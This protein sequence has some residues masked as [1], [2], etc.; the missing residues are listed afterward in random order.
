MNDIKAKFVATGEV[1][2]TLKEPFPM[3]TLIPSAA[4]Y[5]A[6]QVANVV[7]ETDKY[8]NLELDLHKMGMVTDQQNSAMKK[9]NVDFWNQTK[10]GIGAAA[11]L[12]IDENFFSQV[13]TVLTSVDQAFSLRKLADYK[14]EFVQEYLDQM[15][16]KMLAQVIPTFGEEFSE[17]SNIDVVLSLSHN[18]FLKG[19]PDSKRGGFQIDKKGNVKITVNAAMGINFEKDNGEWE[20]ARNIYMTFEYKFRAY[21]GWE[22]YG[23]KFGF[24]PKTL[25]VTKM[26]ILNKEGKEEENE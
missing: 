26:R 8:I 15:N 1:P 16:R 24:A 9:I 6:V 18:E 20:R 25:E 11:Q 21:V 23:T 3:D 7:E 5:Y 14:R 17:D 10:D 2:I 22:S 12:T 4:L 13:F 19:V